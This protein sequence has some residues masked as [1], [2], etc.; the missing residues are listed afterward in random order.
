M[1]GFGFGSSPFLGRMGF[2]IQFA[3]SGFISMDDGMRQVGGG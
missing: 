3:T 2:V 1:V